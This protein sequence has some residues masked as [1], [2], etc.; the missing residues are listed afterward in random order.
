MAS[1]VVPA[2]AVHV[3][4]LDLLGVAGRTSTIRQ[5]KRSNL[6]A[7]G[8]LPSSTTLPSAMSVTVKTRARALGIVRLGVGL[9][10]HA[11][12][13]VGGEPVDATRS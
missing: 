10:L 11:D 12:L 4:V 8:W 2:G 13:D 1:V 3:A 6:P 5:S 9:E 7:H